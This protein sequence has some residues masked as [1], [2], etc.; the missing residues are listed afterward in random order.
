MPKRDPKP[1]MDGAGVD[2]GPV[3]EAYPA[4]EP[5]PQPKR[6][7]QRPLADRIKAKRDPK[8]ERQTP[9]YG[10]AARGHPQLNVRVDPDL[11]RRLER[12]CFEHGLEKSEVIEALI[13][14][15][16]PA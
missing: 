15:H 10:R 2:L 11:K 14:E 13:A 4:A 9:A 3:I 12:Y 5:A 6:Q 7:R 1:D 8:P 16:V